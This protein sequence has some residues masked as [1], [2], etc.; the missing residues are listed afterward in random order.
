MVLGLLVVLMLATVFG[1]KLTIFSAGASEG[2]AIDAAI[3]EYR[4]L[5]PDVEFEHVNITSGWQEKFS[6]ALMSGDAPDLIAITVPYADYFRSY[7]V[8]LAPYVEKHLGISL[9]EYK[10]S[11]Y[12]VVRVYVGKSENE[13]TYVPLYLTV[14]SLWVNVDYFEKAGIS[15][16]PLGGRKDPWTWEEFVNI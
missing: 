3:A 16:P 13:L 1:V 14:H 12:D 9:K 2:N 10:D 15:Y 5:H 8:D 7:L 6:L 4:K 11:M